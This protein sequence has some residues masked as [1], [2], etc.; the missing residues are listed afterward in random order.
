MISGLGFGQDTR[1]LTYDNTPKGSVEK[2]LLL[3][4][5]MSKADLKDDVLCNHYLGKNSP[6]YQP[7][8]G[9]DMPGEYKPIEGLPAAIGVNYGTQLSYCWDTVE[10]RLLYTWSGGFLNMMNYWGDPKQGNRQSFRYVPDLVGNLFYLA[11]GKHPIEVNGVSLKSPKYLGYNKKNGEYTF[12][13][14]TDKNEEIHTTVLPA[15]KHNSFHHRIKLIGNSKLSY[16]P[17]NT[18]TTTIERISDQELV[19]TISQDTIKPYKIV[20]D[21]ALTAKDVSAANG[22]II[23]NK[24]GCITCHS[25]D[26]S[27]SHG[28]TLLGIA[29]SQ[30]SITG[31]KE[32]QLADDAYL[33]ESIL[34]P[35]KKLVEGF[36]A[37]YMP[38]FK[39][40]QHE[41]DALLLYLKTLK[42]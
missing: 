38:F 39:F 33:K 11:E 20:V 5:F 32:K 21:K 14:K 35:N 10:C 29:G 7:N 13:F 18:K 37:N 34:N 17:E 31:M 15:D 1:L 3:R 25:I 6:K 8:T 27:K 9:K 30:R 12:K 42:N 36:P 24:M 23:F 41:F 40:P 28:P 16:K 19:V 22:E 4:T 26:G 2:P